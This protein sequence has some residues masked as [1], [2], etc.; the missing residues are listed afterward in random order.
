M[1][2]FHIERNNIIEP[3]G[4]IDLRI[5]YILGEI[6]EQ[7]WKSMLQQREKKREFKRAKSQ[8]CEM[9]Y[10]IS[11]EQLTRLVEKKQ[12]P[13]VFE[14]TVDNL[15]K[16]IDYYNE[17]MVTVHDRFNSKAKDMFINMERWDF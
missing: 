10:Q 4:N 16:V 7:K 9:L 1:R 8:I 11:R 14:E 15:E 5:N 13:N 17:A 12:S 6:T 2:E 3:D